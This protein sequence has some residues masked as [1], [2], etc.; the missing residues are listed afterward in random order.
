MTKTPFFWPILLVFA[1]LAL[2]AA[3][4]VFWAQPAEEAAAPQETAGA[5]TST[6]KALPDEGFGATDAFSP[7][8]SMLGGSGTP[9]TDD[10]SPEFEEPEQPWEKAINQLLD[11]DEENDKVAASLAALAPTLPLEGQVEAI[12]HMV[13]LLDDE[14]YA[15]AQNMVMNPGLHP[16]VREVLFSDVLDRPNAV[17]LPLLLALLS[18]PGHPL[19]IEAHTNLQAAIGQDL[20]ESPMLWSQPVQAFLEREA[21]EEAEAEAELEESQAPEEAR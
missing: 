17:K 9:V 2:A 20:G 12:Q 15:L 10:L 7:G 8:G 18:S 11:S 19:R 14:Q 21:A 1:A 6:R 5:V 13:N 4:L 3:L 16:D